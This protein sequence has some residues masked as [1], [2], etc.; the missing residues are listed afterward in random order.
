MDSGKDFSTFD[1][2]KK[3]ILKGINAKNTVMLHLRQKPGGIELYETPRAAAWF[4][5]K[6][7]INV[8]KRPSS[9]RSS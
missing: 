4:L 5:L 6:E 9:L 1:N 3:E 7:I 8:F 2:R